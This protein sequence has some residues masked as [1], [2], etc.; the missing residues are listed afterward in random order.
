VVQEL[1]VSLE[2]TCNDCLGLLVQFLT[3][4]SLGLLGRV[5]AHQIVC[6]GHGE[7]FLDMEL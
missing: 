7:P 1:S 3:T 5:Q 6:D 4:L 2:L